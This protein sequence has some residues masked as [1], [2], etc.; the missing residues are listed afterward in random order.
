MSVWGLHAAPATG[1]GLR[2]EGDIGLKPRVVEFLAGQT[3]G[4]QLPFS[5]AA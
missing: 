1:L 5:R 3:R 4:R 2:D